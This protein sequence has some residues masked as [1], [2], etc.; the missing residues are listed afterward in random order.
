[1]IT[2]NF[3]RFGDGIFVSHVDVL[4]SLNRTFRRAGIDVAYSK[5]FNKHMSLKMTQPL[6]L[7]VAD[8]D[9]Y[10]TADIPDLSLSAKQC[11]ALFN[12]FRPPFLE[13][14]AAFVTEKNPS[15][16][17]RINASKYLLR[18]S[19]PSVS[20]KLK[21][22]SSDYEVTVRT[23]DGEK[24]VKG[25]IYETEVLPYGA[26]VTLAFGNVNLRIDSLCRSLNDG[27]GTDFALTDAVRISQLYRE[28]G[29]TRTARELLEE[30][31]TQKYISE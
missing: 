19:D 30:I 13:A 18:S 20:E 4:R 17:G 31:C 28:N 26:E 27:F 1:M 24:T 10:V 16:A 9:C 11:V 7:G 2:I 14:K 15:L 8:E 5:G 25:L 12:E 3:S 6:P 29:V 23:A 21:N 22:F